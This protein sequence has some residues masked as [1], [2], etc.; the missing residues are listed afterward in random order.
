MRNSA[1]IEFDGLY[2]KLKP[3]YNVWDKASLKAY[4][5]EQATFGIVD[6]EKLHLCY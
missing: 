4:M 2:F 5:M 3:A 1:D 6:A